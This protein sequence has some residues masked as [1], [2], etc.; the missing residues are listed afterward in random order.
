[1]AEDISYQIQ[2][3][4]GSSTIAT[5]IVNFISVKHMIFE[6]IVMNKCGKT[7]ATRSSNIAITIVNETGHC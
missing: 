1:M 4:I 5:T 2:L 3:H 7:I 6:L